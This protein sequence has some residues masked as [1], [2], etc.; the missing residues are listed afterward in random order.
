MTERQD[1]GPDFLQSLLLYSPSNFWKGV[2]SREPRPAEPRGPRPGGRAKGALGSMLM[3][4]AT[5]SARPSWPS[6]GSCEG[7]GAWEA[8]GRAGRVAGAARAASCEGGQGGWRELERMLMA[9][10]TKSRSS[11]QAEGY[12]ADSRGIQPTHAEF[13]RFARNSVIQHSGPKSPSTE[14][15]LLPSVFFSKLV[16]L[17]E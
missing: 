3:A 7:P 2:E 12:S 8:E 1:S 10:A 16:L 11:G 6:G 17:F 9:L 5:N 4:L 14:G 13:S 15:T